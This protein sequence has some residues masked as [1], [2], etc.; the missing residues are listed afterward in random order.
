MYAVLIPQDVKIL[1]MLYIV[2]NY[3]MEIFRLEFI[4]QMLVTML[5]LIQH[6][7]YKLAIDA[8]LFI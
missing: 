7:T 2:L 1:T 4:S 3:Q 6:W 8:Q 5:G